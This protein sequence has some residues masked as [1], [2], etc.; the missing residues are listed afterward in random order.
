MAQPALAD[1]R[2]SCPVCRAPV[3]PI[4]GR[5]KHCRA[6]LVRVRGGTTGHGETPVA[7]PILGAGGAPAAAPMPLPGARLG[8]MPALAAI[9]TS[10]VGP[11]VPL[12]HAPSH[13]LPAGTVPL[14]LPAGPA[15]AA[16]PGTVAEPR[17]ARARGGNWSQRWPLL[18]AIVAAL[19]ILASLAVL[20][21]GDDDAKRKPSRAFGPAP[22]RMNTDVQP[23]PA[24]PD[25]TLPTPP[26]GA[27]PPSAQAPS[28]PS[29][30]TDPIDPFDPSPA[31]GTAADPDDPSAQLVPPSPPRAPGVLPTFDDASGF[32]SA[33]VDVGCERMLSCT[34]NSS[35]AQALC[36]QARQ[37]RG[38]LATGLG[39]SCTHFDRAAAQ[40]CL[41]AIAGLPCPGSGNIDASKLSSILLGV[42]ACGRMCGP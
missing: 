6:D 21:F 37:M 25:L 39:L 20:V 2:I 15:M 22:D 19:A 40:S 29:D 11:A 23:P 34:G 7:I 14:A 13:A 12:T 41:R 9:P 3:H 24:M 28:D 4:A 31:P 17:R 38:T 1:A 10:G 5:C 27:L 35:G 26:P 8:A 16:L 33:A 42:P 30:P 32:V 36:S 18:V